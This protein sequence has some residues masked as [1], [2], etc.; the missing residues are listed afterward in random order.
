MTLNEAHKKAVHGD[1]KIRIQ[2]VVFGEWYNDRVLDYLFDHKYEEVRII[3]ED[4]Q[5]IELEPVRNN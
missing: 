3:H 5:C 1:R 2:G 4:E